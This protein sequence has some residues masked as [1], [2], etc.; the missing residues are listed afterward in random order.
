MNLVPSADKLGPGRIGKILVIRIDNIDIL[1]VLLNTE[2]I[3][4][5]LE[6]DLDHHVAVGF[7]AWAQA[8]VS[9]RKD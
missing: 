7:S 5:I 9:C 4:D 6:H 8:G 2:V 3:L 1:R